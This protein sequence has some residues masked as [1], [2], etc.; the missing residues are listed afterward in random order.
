MHHQYLCKALVNLGEFKNLD[1]ADADDKVAN[2]KQIIDKI[3]KQKR[4]S[5]PKDI[6]PSI[7]NIYSQLH[8]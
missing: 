4:Q 8:L 1:K 6:S 3:L 5:S 7:H 2:D